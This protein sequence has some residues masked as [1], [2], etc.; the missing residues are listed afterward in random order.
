SVEG[1]S[2]EWTNGPIQSTVSDPLLHSNPTPP[3]SWQGRIL[4]PFAIESALSGVGKT[5]RPNQLL[6]YRRSV[7]IPGQWRGQRVLLPFE[8]VDWHTIVFVNGK[9]I[10]ENKGGYNHFSFDIKDA[11]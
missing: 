3:A 4:A 7:N 1:E 6:L 9:R 11:L 10:G 8:A 5:V 2:R